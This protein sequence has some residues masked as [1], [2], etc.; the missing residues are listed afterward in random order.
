MSALNQH[1]SNRT[2]ECVPRLVRPLTFEIPKKVQRPWKRIAVYVILAIVSFLLGVVPMWVKAQQYAGQ[3]QT[4]QQELRIKQLESLLA[5]A[6]IS[7]DRGDYELARQTVS[8]FFYS[9]RSQ[10]E[11]GKNSALT[12]PQ[13]DKAKTLLS[14]RDDVITLLARSDPAAVDRLSD[15]YVAYRRAMN[16]INS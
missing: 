16:D 11:Q 12:N 4:A 8:D 5:S 2:L 10:I 14:Q 6:V 7:A 3:R 13:Q 15:L 9:L 1:I